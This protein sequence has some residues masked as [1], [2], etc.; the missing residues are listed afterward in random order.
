MMDGGKRRLRVRGEGRVWFR[1]TIY[2]LAE[3]FVSVS[4]DA[5]AKGAIHMCSV[6]WVHVGR[7]FLTV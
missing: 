1:V 7:D 2:R 3:R 6:E 5:C 4:N